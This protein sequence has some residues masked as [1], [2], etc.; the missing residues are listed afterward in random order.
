[1]LKPY[2]I[3]VEL[4]DDCEVPMVVIAENEVSARRIAKTEIDTHGEFV[5]ADFR[6]VYAAIEIQAGA[7]TIECKE[8]GCLTWLRQ[9]APKNAEQD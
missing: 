2:L 4:T 3:I 9:Y 5:D 6:D 8:S 1:M 7:G